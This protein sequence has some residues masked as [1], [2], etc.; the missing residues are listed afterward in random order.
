VYTIC[1]MPVY[2]FIL[3]ESLPARQ[4]KLAQATAATFV[5]LGL[6][7]FFLWQGIHQFNT[8]TIMLGAAVLIFF[9]LLYF[10]SRFDNLHEDLLRS[11]RFW[12]A[13]G[14]LMYFTG[15]LFYFG[16]MNYLYQQGDH[17]LS[18]VYMILQ[19]MNIMLYLLIGI[20]LLCLKP[21]QTLSPS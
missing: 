6:V 9:S 8:Y 20:A 19:T 7:N 12:V 18:S 5:V 3:K 2:L 10:K 15:T 1:I 4:Q 11:W 21:R 17:W 16:F 14:L 13:A